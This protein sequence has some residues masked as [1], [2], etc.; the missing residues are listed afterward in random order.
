MNEVRNAFPELLLEGRFIFDEGVE[1]SNPLLTCR[2]FAAS[3]RIAVVVTNG[4]TRLQGGTIRVPG[5]HLTDLRTI[6]EATVFT[7]GRVSL[8]QH[9]FAVLV[10]EKDT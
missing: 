7:S 4:E 10:Y 3:D 9:S 6:G 8:R 5:Y 2:A 1:C